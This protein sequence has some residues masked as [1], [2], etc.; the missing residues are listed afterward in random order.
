MEPFLSLRLTALLIVLSLFCA[1]AGA[2]GGV[3]YEDDQCVLKMGYLLAH[4]TGFQPQRRGGEEF[5]ED[6]PEVGEAIFVIEYLHG[7][8]RQMEVDFRVVRDVMDFG[9]YANWDDVVSMGDLSDDTVFYLPPARQPDGVLRARHEFVDSGGYIGVVTASDA[10]SN[11]HYNA[12]FFFYVGDR[13]YLSLLAFAALVLL[14]QLG[15]LASTG[16]LQRFV[17]RRFGKNG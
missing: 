11:K 10:A 16:S 4:F 12:V 5:C 17:K 6:I 7:H 9:V 8:M 3:V 2:H 14:V 1:K 13:S 15:Y